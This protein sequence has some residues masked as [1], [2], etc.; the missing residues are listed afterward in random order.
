MPMDPPRTAEDVRAEF[1]AR[2]IAISEWARENGFSATLVYQVLSGARR[3]LRGQS[4]DIAVALG[5]KD[6]K[7]GYMSDLPFLSRKVSSGGGAE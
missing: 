2:G 1:A 6:G 3:A 7:F 4:H 5:L